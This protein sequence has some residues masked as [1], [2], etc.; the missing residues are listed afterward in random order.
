MKET[1]E[2]CIEILVGMYT[3]FPLESRKVKA[4][5]NALKRVKEKLDEEGDRD[6]ENDTGP[7]PVLRSEDHGSGR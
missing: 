6:A 3:P 4:V 2:Q 5:V 1:I 7:V